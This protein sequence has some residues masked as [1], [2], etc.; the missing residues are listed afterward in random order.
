MAIGSSYLEAVRSCLSAKYIQLAAG[1]TDVPTEIYLYP[2]CE[3]HDQ[4]CL[5]CIGDLIRTHPP[6]GQTD[7]ERRRTDKADSNDKQFAK[8]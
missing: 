7:G 3:E 8:I 6:N 2:Q 1:V 5:V 4:S